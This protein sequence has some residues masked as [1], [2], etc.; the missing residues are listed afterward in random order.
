[1]RDN[2]IG[3]FTATWQIV[4]A[5]PGKLTCP[6]RGDANQMRNDR[7]FAEL[8]FR[9]NYDAGEVSHDLAVTASRPASTPCWE[10]GK[11]GPKLAEIKLPGHG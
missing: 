1:M 10:G 5:R 8:C 3:S 9:A 11:A 7:H 2:A 4:R 6:D